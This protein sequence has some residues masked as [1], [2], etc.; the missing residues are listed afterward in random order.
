[1]E[2]LTTETYGLKYL[3]KSKKLVEN[4]VGILSI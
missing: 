2:K 3:A 1:M 4:L